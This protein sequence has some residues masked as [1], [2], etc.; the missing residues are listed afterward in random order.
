M[1]DCVL[2][3]LTADAFRH[4]VVEQPA[5]L[6]RITAAVLQRQEELA[7]TRANASSTQLAETPTTFLQKVRKFLK[8]G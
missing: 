8:V 1:T 5:V 4:F 7:R 3:E 6:E 2:M